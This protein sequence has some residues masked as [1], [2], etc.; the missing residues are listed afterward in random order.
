LP[1]LGGA[2]LIETEEME[3]QI[4]SYLLADGRGRFLFGKSLLG[5]RAMDS[6]R[7]S[8]FFFASYLINEDK[9]QTISYTKKTKQN[10]I[11]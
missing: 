2:N 9:P 7:A 10:K 11:I 4:D 3:A 1:F 6:H 5:I 8:L